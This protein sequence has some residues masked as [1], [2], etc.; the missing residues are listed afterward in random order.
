M[1]GLGANN[2]YA[3]PILYNLSPNTPPTFTMALPAGTYDLLYDRG[4]SSGDVPVTSEL[5]PAP[6]AYRTVNQ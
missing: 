4:T 5:E 1:I 3:S 2:N 6:M